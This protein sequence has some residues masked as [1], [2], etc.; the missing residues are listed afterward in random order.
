ME[1]PAR[2]AVNNFVAAVATM[3][4]L[5]WPAGFIGLYPLPRFSRA[6]GTGLL[7]TSRLNDFELYRPPAGTG[8]DPLTTTQ[9]AFC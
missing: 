8:L 7:T 4:D 1:G 9:R 5:R 6:G 3:R 2:S